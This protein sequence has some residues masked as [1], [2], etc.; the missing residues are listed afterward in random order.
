MKKTSK[1]QAASP[2]PKKAATGRPTASPRK[3]SERTSRTEAESRARAV[4]PAMAAEEQADA[5]ERA[6][7]LFHARDYAGA[8]NI[9]ETA[10]KGPVAAMAH[11]ARVHARMCEMRLSQAQPQLETAD[12]HYNY[13]V[14]LINMR[15]LADAEKHLTKALEIYPNADHL[16]YA[17]A[18][19]R[20]LQGDF[21]GAHRHMKRA[22]DIQPRNRAL[23][24]N[25]PDFAELI[26]RGSLR[27][28]LYP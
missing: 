23:A 10:A 13:A 15:R 17:L 16:H 19:T 28:L 25:D 18:L 26:Q 14:G 5:F 20:G 2:A 24:R 22:I 27:E 3:S 6:M 4:P 12:D 7:R 21:E 11:T 1:S 8:R 9:F